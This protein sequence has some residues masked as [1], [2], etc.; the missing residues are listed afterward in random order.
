MPQLKKYEV[1][2]E[3]FYSYMEK[4]CFA[5]PNYDI[6]TILVDFSV[7]VEQESYLCPACGGH[8]LHIKTNDN[9]K[10]M[11]NSALERDLAVI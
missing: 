10:Q 2:R 5:V 7:K 6:K 11:L 4:L 3:E 9:G 8:S 1:V